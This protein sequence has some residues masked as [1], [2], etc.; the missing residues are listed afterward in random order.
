MQQRDKELSGM[1]EKRT[2]DVEGDIHC[3]GFAWDRAKIDA[4][5]RYRGNNLFYVSMY[6]HLYSR[7]E[8]IGI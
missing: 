5:A 7:G 3:H 6:D 2:D 8:C 4:I 1:L